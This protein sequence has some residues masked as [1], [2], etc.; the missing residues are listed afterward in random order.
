MQNK[1][2]IKMG[3]SE[4]PIEKSHEQSS[5]VADMVIATGGTGE[6]NEVHASTSCMHATI[7][8]LGNLPHQTR[9]LDTSN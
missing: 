8:T 7:P 3:N 9:P 4:K 6:S 5:G 1:S 2:E